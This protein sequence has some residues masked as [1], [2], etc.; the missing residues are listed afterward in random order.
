M[1]PQLDTLAAF[2]H[3]YWRRFCYVLGLKEAPASSEAVHKSEE[4][5]RLTAV[6]HRLELHNDEECNSLVIY[7]CDQY[8]WSLPPHLYKPIFRWSG[9]HPDLIE[10]IYDELRELFLLEAR[11]Q[12]CSEAR[13]GTSSGRRRVWLG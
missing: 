9:G 13:A 3:R 8:G 1:V 12:A 5:A 4:W 10:T 2:Q 6:T 7:L 11:S